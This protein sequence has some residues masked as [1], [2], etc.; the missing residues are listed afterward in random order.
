MRK[1]K[2]SLAE[3]N[4]TTINIDEA[5]GMSPPA[6]QGQIRLFNSGRVLKI[7]GIHKCILRE[8]YD[9]ISYVSQQLCTK[10]ATMRL[11]LATMSIGRSTMP[12]KNSNLHCKIQLCTKN[13][14]L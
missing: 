8:H 11:E 1:P 12:R 9:N 6:K 10:N 3:E 14:Q 4:K 13:S 2:Q 5:G 7:I